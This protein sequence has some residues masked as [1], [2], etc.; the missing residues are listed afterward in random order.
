MEAGAAPKPGTPDES[1]P[2]Q[3]EM[4]LPSDLRTAFEGG[5]FLLALSLSSMRRERSF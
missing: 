4:P 5:L 1:T 3:V 2:E